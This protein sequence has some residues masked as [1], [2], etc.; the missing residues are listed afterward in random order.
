MVCTVIGAA[1]RR[2]RERERGVE[3]FLGEDRVLQ[4]SWSKERSEKKFGGELTESTQT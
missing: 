3:G 2:E 1:N 4:D